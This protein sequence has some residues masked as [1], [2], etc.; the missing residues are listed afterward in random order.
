MVG[1]DYEIKDICTTGVHNAHN[2]AVKIGPAIAGL[3]VHM[4]LQKT[5]G[6]GS[7]V[8]TN[9]NASAIDITTDTNLVLRG[10]QYSTVLSNMELRTSYAGYNVRTRKFTKDD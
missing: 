8:F 6:Q 5:S 7:A 10:V 4:E 3:T 2:V 1:A 9:N